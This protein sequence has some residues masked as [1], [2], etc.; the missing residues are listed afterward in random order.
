MKKIKVLLLA[1][2]IML[3]SV[4]WNVNDV[5]AASYP[6]FMPEQYSSTYYV[7]DTITLTYDIFPEY[8]NESL[9]LNIYDEDGNSIGSAEESFYNY[10]TFHRTY[11]VNWDT[12]GE[13]AGTYEVV[14]TMQFYTYF[15]WRECP[16]AKT[17]TIT[18]VKKPKYGVRVKSVKNIKGSKI[19]VKWK[20]VSKAKKYQVRIGK[21]KYTTKKTVIISKKLKKEEWYDVSVRA[22]VGGKFRQWSPARSV[23]TEK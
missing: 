20:K 11:S 19:K 9:S 16:S 10:D 18:L 15:E 7:G 12:K 3:S 1:M 13:A 8:K 2:I 17:S 21:K 23:Y 5:D 14:A 4:T 22:Y 6:L